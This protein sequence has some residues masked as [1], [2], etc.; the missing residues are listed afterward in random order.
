MKEKKSYIFIVQNT[1]DDELYAA[2][3]ID[4]DLSLKDAEVSQEDIDFKVIG[5][6]AEP[7]A[8]I[9]LPVDFNENQIEWYDKEG[10]SPQFIKRAVLAIINFIK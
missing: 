10:H 4:I 2:R 9:P 1:N 7:A 8:H 5:K 3:Q 6:I